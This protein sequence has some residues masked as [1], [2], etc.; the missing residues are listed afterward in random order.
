MGPGIKTFGD[1]QSIMEPE[2]RQKTRIYDPIF[3]VVRGSDASGATYQFSTIARNI[4]PGGLCAYTPQAMEVGQNLT[5][6]I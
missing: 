4:G 1:S 6:Q 5:I 2:R 3:I